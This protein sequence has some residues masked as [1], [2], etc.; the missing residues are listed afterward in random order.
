MALKRQK[1]RAN[2]AYQRF[3]DHRAKKIWQEKKNQFTGAV[4][5]H[6]AETRERALSELKSTDGL[7][8]KIK[9]TQ[10]SHG[11]QLLSEGD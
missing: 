2:K 4:K 7:I 10:N 1:Q 6:K 8:T 11:I 9:A 5:A 3:Q